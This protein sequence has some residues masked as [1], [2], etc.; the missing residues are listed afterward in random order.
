M[1]LDLLTSETA[2]PP[3]RRFED[4]CGLAH[5]MDLVG[6]RWA[7]QVIRE[8][9][10]GPRRFGDLRADLV[11]LSANVLSQRLGELEQ[12][13]I[14]R[15][16]R[17]PPPASVPVYALT[18][19]GQAA[20]P[21]L[22]EMARWAYRSATHDRT[23]PLGRVPMLL[24]LKANLDAGTAADLRLTAGFRFGDARYRAGLKGGQLAIAAAEPEGTDFTYDG[25]PRGLAA[26]IYGKAPLDAL[27]EQ[28]A[29]RLTGDAAQ[30]ARFA[31]LFALPPRFA[32][33]GSRA[34][35]TTS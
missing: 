20:E 21:M 6:E 16:H 12:R 1:K 8:L 32:A 2:A 9:L 33:D 14:V 5:A 28:G 17:L 34:T 7:L 22:L 3:K 27:A 30:E 29:L 11:G 26:H 15:R 35:A 23:A 18:D 13:G 31:A 4:A 25:T 19:F 10:L 24:S